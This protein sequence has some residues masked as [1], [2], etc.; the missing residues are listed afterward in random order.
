MQVSVSE[1]LLQF[2]CRTS[3]V[4]IPVKPNQVASLSNP[5]RKVQTFRLIFERRIELR[6]ICIVEKLQG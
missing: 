2:I 5:K 6:F 1:T 3:S 4:D